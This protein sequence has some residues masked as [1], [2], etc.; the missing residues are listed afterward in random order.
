MIIGWAGGSGSEF[1]W[2]VKFAYFIINL[3]EYNI[4]IKLK[5]IFS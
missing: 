5:L 3:I 1:S 2:K 4:D